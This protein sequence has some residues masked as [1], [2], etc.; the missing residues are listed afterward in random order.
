VKAALACVAALLWQAGNFGGTR[1]TVAPL[2]EPQHLRYERALKLPQGASG[3]A[4]AILDASV[5][6]HSASASIGDLRVFQNV[7]SKSQREIPFAVSY[8][9]AQPTDATTATV[10]NVTLQNGVLSFDLAMPGRL[11]TTVELMLAAKNFIGTAEVSGSDGKGGPLTALGSFEIFDLTQ[12]H[13][14]RSTSLPLQESNFAELHVRLRLHSI[15]GGA[16]PNISATMI[17]GA[18]VPASREAQTLYTVV[19][20]SK[21]I[22]QQN[23]STVIKMVAPAHVPLEQVRFELNPSFKEDFLRNVSI[24][25]ASDGQ[26]LDAPE[27]S[28]DGQIWRVTR[29]DDA[30]DILGIHAAKLTVAAVLASNLRDV[31]TI[32]VEVKNGNDTPLPIQAVELEMRQRTVCFNATAGTAYTLRYGD[33]AL[34]PS[35]YNLDGLRTMPAKPIVATLGREE[36]NRGYVGRNQISTYKERNPEMYWLALLAAIA[37]FGALGARHTRHRGRHR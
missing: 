19:A 25:A 34:Q 16:L 10:G 21:T 18:T 36:L 20:T 13:L 32:R 9:A 31:A 33:D 26:A 23:G 17:E 2:A 15:D 29:D 5:F 27:E 37:A 8:S 4:C 3:T 22:I 28:I 24:S 6:A 11:Y 30:T 35:V 14:A 7:A 12:R 1:I